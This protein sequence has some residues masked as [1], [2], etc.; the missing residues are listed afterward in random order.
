MPTPL[1]RR[2]VRP[3]RRKCFISYH[4]A[5]HAEVIEF[6]EHFG[7]ANFIH[8]AITMPEDVVNSSDTDYVMR[9][10]RELYIQDSTVTIVLV[11][12]CTWARKFVDWEVQASLRP[13]AN[14]LLVILLDS[15]SVPPLP[16]RVKANIDSGYA[17][18]RHYPRSAVE[19]GRWIEHAHAGR[20]SRASLRK[21]SRVRK[22]NNSPCGP[23]RRVARK[24]KYGF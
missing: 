22:F 11:G 9:R 13:P 10:I 23:Q 21:N 14:G 20:T 12:K 4:H 15:A 8:R 24:T 19:L 5:D 7:R 18:G 2:L 3:I 1:S 6:I 17:I 16:A